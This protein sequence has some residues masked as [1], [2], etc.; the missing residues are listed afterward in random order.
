MGTNLF[1]LASSPSAHQ[2][3]VPLDEWILCPHALVVQ[4]HVEGFSPPLYDRVAIA[5]LSYHLINEV[6]GFIPFGLQLGNTAFGVRKPILKV[7]NICI[8][9][10]HVCKISDFQHTKKQ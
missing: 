1:H 6:T 2:V 8:L 7:L 4:G 3:V 5:H 10:F 9:L